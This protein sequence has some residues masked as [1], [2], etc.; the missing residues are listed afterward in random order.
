MATALDGAVDA[1]A[2]RELR[3]DVY[4]KPSVERADLARL[5]EFGRRAGAG[6]PQEYADLLADV[7]TDLLVNQA[8]PPKYISPEDAKWLIGQLSAGSGLGCSAEFE[9][10]LAVLR[11]AVSIPPALSSFAVGEIERAI[12]EGHY[13]AGGL[14]DHVAGIVTKRDVEALRSCVF[15][16]TEGSSLHVT[17]ESAEALFRI[18]HATDVAKNDPSFDEFFAQAI[19]NYLMGIAFHWT[20]SVAEE[21]QRKRWLDEP[22]PA[23]GGFLRGFLHIGKTEEQRAYDAENSRL[24]IE[25]DAD[26]AELA[27]K[28]NID[29]AEADW[30]LSHLTRA[31]GVTPAEKRLLLFLRENAKSISPTLLQAIEAEAK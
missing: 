1:A 14:P 10:L 25:N 21:T 9:M 5:L 31:G 19:G 24:K 22:P 27:G 6:T 11:Y 12:L 18:A 2:V 16:A 30:V 13:A 26:L 20:P 4:S 23:A 8:D 29:A 3:R 17:R 15:A 7:A 28:A